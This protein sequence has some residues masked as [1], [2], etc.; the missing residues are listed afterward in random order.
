MRIQALATTIAD[1][2]LT[3]NEAQTR[4]QSALDAFRLSPTQANR[5][6]VTDA[7]S[8]VDVA[9]TELALFTDQRDAELAALKDP[10]RSSERELAKT[11]AKA[12][13]KA[14]KKRA[15]GPALAIDKWLAD[16]DRL[17]NE[18]LQPG[19][20]LHD[21][22]AQTMRLAHPHVEERIQRL[23]VMGLY[24]KSAQLAAVPIATAI[25]RWPAELCQMTL[26]ALQSGSYVHGAHYSVA[27]ASERAARDLEVH[28]ADGVDRPLRVEEAIAAGQAIPPLA[29]PRDGRD[30]ALSRAYR[31]N[32]GEFP[33]LKQIEADEALM[34]RTSQP[35][36]AQ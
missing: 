19:E 18:F 20:A 24:T 31:T 35:E 30:N 6:R 1:V 27:A 5:Q 13:V 32:M 34:K 33:S 14:A 28:L 26:Q 21:D 16:G 17:I 2:E 4:Y 10:A 8:A 7:K 25:L 36:D 23:G 9:T 3:R 29:Q 11:R 12:H 22:V 15:E